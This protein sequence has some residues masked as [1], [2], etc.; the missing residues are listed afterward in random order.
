MRT[1]L[2]TGGAGSLGRT[3]AAALLEAGHR[4][5]LADIS[6][7]A[8]ARALEDLGHSGQVHGLAADIGTEAGCSQLVAACAS[9]APVD[10]L[11]NNA[12][13]GSSSIRPDGELNPPRLDE[14][15]R[16]TWER[17]FA[18]NVHAAQTLTRAFV[19]GMVRQGWGRIVNNTTSFRTMLRVLPY[20]ATKSALEAMTAI[21]A[22]ELRGTGVTSNVL[23]PGGPTD[24][25]FIADGAGWAREDM[26]RPE[27][28]GPPAVW[29]M[30]LDADGYSGQ[31]ISAAKWAEGAAGPDAP[32]AA[33]RPV[34]WPELAA[35]AVWVAKD[36]TR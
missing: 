35:D 21:W 10:A 31:R 7:D 26:L 16:V 18:V 17:F 23:V 30:S 14:L 15:D 34:A 13:I 22:D 1:I 3:M 6:D 4:V 25:P 20:G 27:I 8:L 5:I 2:I 36:D 12:G 28:M 19:P 29:L 24:T 9:I 32:G 33:G 11:I